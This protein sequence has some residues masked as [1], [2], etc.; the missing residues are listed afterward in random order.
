MSY[1]LVKNFRRLLEKEWETHISHPY[2]EV[3]HCADV[4]ANI[5]CELNTNMLFILMVA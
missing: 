4:M 3:N 2:M 5:E 1:S